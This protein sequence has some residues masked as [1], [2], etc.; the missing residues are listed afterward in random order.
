MRS[1]R[2]AIIEIDMVEVPTL[3]YL[4]FLLGGD[5]A[6]FAFDWGQH[7]GNNIRPHHTEK[8][9]V[10][11]D[12]RYII[13]DT[14][15]AALPAVNDLGIA[16][17][18]NG[19][20][21]PGGQVQAF[22]NSLFGQAIAILARA[23][24]IPQDMEGAF[25]L[26]VMNMFAE[27]YRGVDDQWEAGDSEE[28][29]CFG[30]LMHEG[31]VTVPTGDLSTS[32]FTRLT[33]N[34][35][36]TIDAK[37]IAAKILGMTVDIHE[38]RKVAEVVNF[39]IQHSC[40]RIGLTI[41]I[42]F[43]R[44]DWA[45]THVAGVN[46]PVDDVNSRRDL[47]ERLGRAGGNGEASVLMHMADILTCKMFN[48]KLPGPFM[49]MD[50]SSNDNNRRAPTHGQTNLGE[51]LVSVHAAQLPPGMLSPEMIGY[52]GIPYN[53][54]TM[55]KELKFQFN[56]GYYE[57]KLV[58]GCDVK[59]PNES[60]AQFVGGNGQGALGHSIMLRRD[61]NNDDDDVYR[62]GVTQAMP[63][64]GNLARMGA[65]VVHHRIARYAFGEDDNFNALDQ[66]TH[67]HIELY[68]DFDWLSAG[69]LSFMAPNNAR[70]KAIASSVDTKN[71]ISTY[72]W[73]KIMDSQ[74]TGRSPMLMVAR[75]HKRRK[76]D[77]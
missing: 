33:D 43:P 24:P 2:I 53:I 21:P 17:L 64:G 57:A 26:E 1:S 25:L 12:Y 16:G 19:P 69:D 58:S 29:R 14:T 23:F 11:F 35:Q 32:M 61:A 38:I 60:N 59:N 39:V 34:R 13:R 5:N 71:K 68:S 37:E 28:G 65:I 77:G 75:V 9:P 45:A 42:V 66:M 50:F 44:V 41:P 67:T 70:G 8:N 49:V 20:A 36:D 63:K 72:V 27:N 30:G 7:G 74:I 73:A 52:A 51:C 46:R 18:P 56:N 54:G 22:D 15:G 4:N 62:V 55:N 40:R 76:I 48:A 6:M 31:E 3:P 47:N 10:V